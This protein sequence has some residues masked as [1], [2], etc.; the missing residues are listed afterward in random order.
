MDFSFLLIF[1][2]NQRY[3][4]LTKVHHPFFYYLPSKEMGRSELRRRSSISQLLSQP[5][6]WLRELKVMVA[7]S[8]SQGQPPRANYDPARILGTQTTN[9]AVVANSLTPLASFCP[10]KSL[11]WVM[12]GRELRPNSGL[13]SSSI[14]HSLLT[15]THGSYCTALPNKPGH[16]F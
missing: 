12:A 14:P 3:L 7:G 13:L 5:V 2:R 1:S 6:A 15:G 10:G 16:L 4:K 11:R 8:S 9:A